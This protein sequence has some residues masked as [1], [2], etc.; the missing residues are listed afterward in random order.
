MKLP[1]SSRVRAKDLTLKS[2]EALG[3]EGGKEKGGKEGR[4][5]SRWSYLKQYRQWLAPHGKRLL[6]LFGL[7]V[8]AALLDLVWPLLIKSM[9]DFLATDRTPGS[10]LQ[11]LLMMCFGGVVLLG[12]KQS[13]EMY[14]SYQ[15][16]V[17]NAKLLF[18][19]R[20]RLFGALLH[21]PL[22]KLGEFKSGGIVSRLGADVDQVGG[23]VQQAL[24]APSVA[25]LRIVLTIGVLTYLSWQLAL[26]TLFALPPAGLMTFLWLR[27]VRPVYRSMME[28]RTGVDARVGETFG[29]IRVVRAFRREKREARQYAVGSHTVI[30]KMLRA[31]RVEFI[32]ENGWGLLIPLAVLVVVVYGGYLVIEG[33]GK[34]GD[35]F[36]FQIYAMLL[37]GPVIQIV[38][39]VSQT[40]KS[41]AA[42]ERVFDTL[43]EPMDKPDRPGAR[44]AL[45]A[46][47]VVEEMRFEGVGFAYREDV[48]V[49]REINLTVR[50]GMTVA[51]VG[52]SGAGKTTLTDLVCRF[53]D[54][55]VGRITLNGVDLR[56]IRLAS[57]RSLLAVVQQETFLF[58]GSVHDNIAYG[59]RR[60]T[61][62]D[63]IEAARRA[64]AHEFISALPEGYDTQI[65]ERGFKLS[66]G[67]R[68]R[69]SIARAMLAN[70]KI[71]ILDEATSNL[72]TE[73]EQ[74]IQAALADLLNSQNGSEGGRTSFVIAHRL[75][76]ITHADLIVV[77]EQGRIVETGNHEQLLA[78]RGVYFDMVERQ[79]LSMGGG[80]SEG[81]RDALRPVI[82]NGESFSGK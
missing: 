6:G 76:T 74:L 62:Q 15:T 18:R 16:A 57:Y 79:R 13:I 12:V 5:R 55:S 44:E 37:L 66:G 81:G 32:L 82:E 73:S 3:G 77:M 58:D 4:K 23:L 60:A 11:W 40:Q 61:R 33:R 24:I 75:S 42:M 17:V 30:R 20:R 52:A 9:V 7:A 43:A 51:L 56:D 59:K 22:G 36:A 27:K 72:D 21:L 49:L 41:L 45:G 71:L 64:N 70:P 8:V 78:A 14:R 67:Q 39:S 1:H 38:A 28:D 34:I 19:L 25:V 48:P 53:H 69:L 46:T 47:G 35:I 26:A 10:K 63:V 65:G 2:Q 54:P 29:G 50:G 31:N 80:V 68:Q